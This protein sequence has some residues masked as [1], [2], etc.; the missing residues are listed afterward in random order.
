M[1]LTE[2]R[3]TFAASIDGMKFPTI[4]AENYYEIIKELISAILLI[5]GVKATGENAHKEL[6]EEFSKYKEL[7]E[8]EIRIIDDLRIRRNKSSYEGKQIESSYLENK[9]D[10]LIKIIKEIKVILKNKLK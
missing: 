8:A 5:D 10:T 7:D 1:K 6:I 3:E 9:K 4:L 2:E